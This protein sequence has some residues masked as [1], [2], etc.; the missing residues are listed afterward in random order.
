MLSRFG[1]L[2]IVW[3]APLI[4]EALTMCIAA[5]LSRRVMGDVRR[6]AADRLPEPEA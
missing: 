6:E 3:L 4:A 1:R 2:E 5:A